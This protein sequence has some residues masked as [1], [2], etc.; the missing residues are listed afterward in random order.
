M[1]RCSR[2][3]FETANLAHTS[4]VP[5]AIMV[6]EQIDGLPVVIICYLSKVQYSDVRSSLHSP[7]EST[8]GTTRSQSGTVSPKSLVNLDGRILLE[9]TAENNRR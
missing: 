9:G 3:F 4:G 6:S 5:H 2:V 7:N 1:V 8:P